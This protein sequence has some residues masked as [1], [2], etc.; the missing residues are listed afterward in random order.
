[1]LLMLRDV[2]KRIG[3]FGQTSSLETRTGVYGFVGTGQKLAAIGERPLGGD[4]HGLHR[5]EFSVKVGKVI[6]RIRSRRSGRRRTRR[7]A[8]RP[9]QND[10]G[11]ES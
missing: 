9:Q 2:E 4:I 10:R 1:M 5:S 11:C 7:P 8:L 6:R 3:G